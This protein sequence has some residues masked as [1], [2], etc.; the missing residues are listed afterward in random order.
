MTISQIA[1]QVVE[2]RS[3]LLIRYRKDSVAEGQPQYDAKELFTGSKRGWTALDLFT[4]QALCA[5]HGA[6]SPEHHA[7]FD[8]MPINKL[9]SFCLSKVGVAR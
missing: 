5:V 6:L 3:A 8:R 2:T 4:A 9:A 1:K 7:K